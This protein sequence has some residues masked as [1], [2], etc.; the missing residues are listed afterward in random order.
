MAWQASAIRLAPTA[1]GAFLALVASGGAQAAP[2]PSLAALAPG[3][4]AVVGGALVSWLS[5]APLA[6]MDWTTT[7]AG[8]LIVLAAG[9]GGAVGQSAA[10]VLFLALLL[11][12]GVP[13][14]AHGLAPGR[15]AID[16]R[17]AAVAGVLG[18]PPTLGFVGRMLLFGQLLRHGETGALLLVAGATALTTARWRHAVA[19]PTDAPPPRAP[20][21]GMLLVLTGLDVALGI[22]YVLARAGLEDVLRMPLPP[23]LPAATGRAAVVGGAILL[24]LLAGMFLPSR[25]W[26]LWPVSTSRR[27]ATLRLV[28]LTEAFDGVRTLLIRLGRIVHNSV[29][30]IE[31]RGMMAWTLLAALV[32]GAVLLESP[33]PAAGAGA[34]APG[35]QAF[36]PLALAMIVAAGMLLAASPLATLAALVVGYVLVFIMHLS[37][38]AFAAADPL[39]ATAM[40]QL[41]AGLV[42]VAI[43]AISVLQGP[44]DRRRGHGS[45]RWRS[46]GV[47]QGPAVERRL[48]AVGLAVAL[49]GIT[50][51]S[52]AAQ[53]L[54]LPE[55]VLQPA[56]AL[57]AGGALT[58]V[59]ARTPLRLTGGVMLA[60][61][62]FGLVYAR[63]ETGLLIG[64]GLAAFQL[65]F[66]IVS[67]A[68]VA[69]SS[70]PEAGR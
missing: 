28:G 8:G 7:F 17:V 35:W 63:L 47:A 24:P 18:I 13:Y 11:E 32:T 43:L 9:T 39:V 42:V 57:I 60:W 64:G 49:L 5:S 21:A 48:P 41:V 19:R 50:G 22:G 36:A 4:L 62:G 58:A 59:F 67:S 56:L 54:T 30:L 40:I 44:S 46:L 65:L 6:A 66:A 3:L 10:I 14:I 61:C 29:G 1:A 38:A 2:A 68:F 12:C 31:G 69:L 70:R 45:P 37:L 16:A 53:P 15:A 34:P 52:S 33:V 20:L 27:E 26:S 25:P 51:I 55:T 23:V